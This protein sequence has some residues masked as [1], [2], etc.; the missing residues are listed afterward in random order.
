MNG[1]HFV[2][3][4]EHKLLP[5]LPVG[6]AVVM[7]NAPYHTIKTKESRA[8]T[9]KTLK[10]DIQVWLTERNLSWKGDKLESELYELVKKN[11]PGPQYV[12]DHMTLG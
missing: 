11:K 9:S 10:A 1:D 8:P 5:N 7:D 6:A 3:W 4:F 12:C 2:E